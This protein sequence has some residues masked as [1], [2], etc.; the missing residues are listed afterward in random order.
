MAIFIRLNLI[1]MDDAIR[2][3]MDQ[4]VFFQRRGNETILEFSHYK[5]RLMQ[6]FMAVSETPDIIQ[7]KI[8]AAE[9]AKNQ[10]YPNS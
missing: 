1:G 6:S 7:D 3:N 10:N 2:V 8:D 4:V 9:K 5:N